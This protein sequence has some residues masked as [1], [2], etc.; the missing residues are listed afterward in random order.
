MSSSSSLARGSCANQSGST[1]TWQVEHAIWP[2]HVPFQWLAIGLCR[3]R[4]ASRPLRLPLRVP[5]RRRPRRNGPVIMQQRSTGRPAASKIRRMPS[6]QFGKRRV[7]AKADADAAARFG[8]LQAD[9]AAAHGWAAP[10]RSRR[11]IPRQRRR[12]AVRKS[13]APHP[14]VTPDIEVALVTLRHR[15]VDHPACGAALPG[16][17]PELCET[18]TASSSIR[19]RASVAAVPKPMHSAGDSVPERNAAFLPAAEKQRLDLNAVPHPQRPDALW[20]RG[21]CAR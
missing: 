4:A 1:I 2:S 20:A 18:C 8:I 12:R 21:F 7:A 16:Q 9:G 5:V 3:L 11:P 19:C 10:I 14:P 17:F 13:A 15:T 6:A